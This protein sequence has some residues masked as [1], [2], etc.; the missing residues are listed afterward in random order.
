MERFWAQQH[1]VLEVLLDRGNRGDRADGHRVGLA[2]QG[3]GMRG[4]ISGAMLTALEDLGLATSFDAIYGTSSGAMNGAYLYQGGVSRGLSVYWDHLHSRD[5]ID[6]RRLLTGGSVLDMASVFDVVMRDLVPF[7]P[8]TVLRADVPLHVVITLVDELRSAAFSDF[9]SAADL[10]AALRASSWLP[11]AVRGTALFRGQRALDGFVL[12]VHP[13]HF[14]LADGCTHVLSLSTR[15]VG[16][17]GDPSN[18]IGARL[19]DWRLDQIRA[20]L[21]AGRA[22]A[23]TQYRKDRL[24]LLRSSIAPSRTPYLLDLAPPPWMPR[25]GSLELDPGKLMLAARYAYELVVH[26]VE[27]E[28]LDGLRNRRFRSVP[29]FFLT[30]GS[31]TA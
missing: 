29:R 1:P 25:I 7:H 23:A 16:P 6:L 28:S 12:T 21:G 3:G 18:S 2:I 9:E 11:V 10:L 13:F 17:R 8:E 5:F 24:T 15:P 31:P 30:R 14:A 20:G 4:V 27:D 26:L 22:K 19:L